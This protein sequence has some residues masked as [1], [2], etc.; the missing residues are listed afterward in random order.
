MDEKPLL[1]ERGKMENEDEIRDHGEQR[2]E[3]SSDKE[4]MEDMDAH[5]FRNSPLPDLAEDGHYARTVEE[6]VIHGV[7]VPLVILADAAYP[8]KPWLMKPYGGNI[9]DP[10]KL[11]FNYHMSSFRMAVECVFG[12]LKG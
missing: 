11:V 1:M 9:T 10:Q 4:N 6:T 5:V 8:I 3:D 2:S 7:A 12:Q